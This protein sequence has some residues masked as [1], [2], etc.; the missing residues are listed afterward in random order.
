MLINLNSMEQIAP[1]L[2]NYGSFSAPAEQK[3]TG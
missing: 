1:V 2:L 3:F